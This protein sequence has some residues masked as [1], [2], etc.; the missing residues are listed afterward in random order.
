MYAFMETPPPPC[1]HLFAFWLPIHP[2]PSA[3]V[4]T[5]WMLP[6]SMHIPLCNKYLDIELKLTYP[7]TKFYVLLDPLDT[8]TSISYLVVK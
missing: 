6:Y 4:R 7:N 1:T 3:Y 2:S 8:L 5:L